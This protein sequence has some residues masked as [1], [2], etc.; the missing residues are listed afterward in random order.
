MEDSILNLFFSF[1][2]GI[3]HI[4]LVARKEESHNLIQEKEKVGTLRERKHRAG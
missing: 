1:V 4:L 3:T 2:S